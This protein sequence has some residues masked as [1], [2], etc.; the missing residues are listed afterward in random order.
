MLQF[1]LSPFPSDDPGTILIATL[2]A[3]IDLSHGSVCIDRADFPLSREI[4]DYVHAL[5]PSGF[6]FQASQPLIITW[7]DV[8]FP[9][10][11]DPSLVCV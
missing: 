2:A 7:K 8:T 10:S 11:T 1:P 3:E 6:F 5:F 4:Q 9:D